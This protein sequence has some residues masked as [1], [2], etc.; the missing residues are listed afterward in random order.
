QINDLICINSNKTN[1]KKIDCCLSILSSETEPLVF[2][3]FLNGESENILVEKDSTDVV[4]NEDFDKDLP[5][6]LLNTEFKID[7]TIY[8][9][10]IFGISDGLINLQLVWFNYCNSSCSNYFWTTNFESY[11]MYTVKKTWQLNISTGLEFYPITPMKII[12]GDMILLNQSYDGKVAIN[13]SNF[14]SD[15]LVYLKGSRFNVSRLSYESLNKFSVKIVSNETEIYHA[16]FSKTYQSTGTYQ[17]AVSVLNE[18]LKKTVIITDRIAFDLYYTNASSYNLKNV[19]LILS[20]KN[21]TNYDLSIEK[22]ESKVTYKLKSDL[23]S[24]HGFNFAKNES[25]DFWQNE[26]L[27]LSTEFIMDLGLVG[28]EIHAWK[29]GEITISILSFTSCGSSISCKLYF[30]KIE[31]SYYNSYK[32][33]IDF[34]INVTLGFN[35]I[36]L[37]YN[38]PMKKGYVLYLKQNSEGRVSLDTTSD[39]YEDYGVNLVNTKYHLNK[40]NSGSKY[41]FCINPLIDRMIYTS[42]LVFDLG[43]ESVKNNE[44][45]L[46]I[47]NT[48]VFVSTKVTVSPEVRNLDIFCADA[49]KT[50]DQRINCE[51]RAFTTNKEDKIE[52]AF[53]EDENYIIKD[54]SSKTRKILYLIFRKK[55]FYSV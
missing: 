42:F 10:E 45:N 51:V 9:F 30:D 24:F 26:Y 32:S 40:L 23:L 14:L 37:P 27:L 2:V 50:L 3:D 53:E 5:I 38:Y 39:I 19:F 29:S 46:T 18:T 20:E 15:L 52:I 1:D 6:L 16:K 43:F 44:F 22:L 55:F 41:R 21:L 48:S 11:D 36:R 17:I 35:R 12:K 47:F 54:I 33:L 31:N 7:S 4:S 25:L 8:G 49:K 34:K 28:F 13:P